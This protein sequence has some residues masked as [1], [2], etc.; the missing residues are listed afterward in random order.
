MPA[1]RAEGE[2]TGIR[3]LL[4]NRLDMEGFWFFFYL[5]VKIYFCYSNLASML[6]HTECSAGALGNDLESN[7][8]I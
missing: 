2:T 3:R 7:F 5:S 4:L 6:I 8:G 1:G